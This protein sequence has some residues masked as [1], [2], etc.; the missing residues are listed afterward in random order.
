MTHEVNTTERIETGA[1][2]HIPSAFTVV[3]TPFNVEAASVG[4]Q[5]VLDGVQ[6]PAASQRGQF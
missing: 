4:V 6:N 5:E 2:I 3:D 1:E